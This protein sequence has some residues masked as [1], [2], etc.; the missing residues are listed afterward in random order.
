[1]PPRQFSSLVVVGAFRPKAPFLAI[2]AGQRGRP[3][4]RR[5][6]VPRVMIGSSS[7]PVSPRRRVPSPFRWGPGSPACRPP[8]LLGQTR[9]FRILSS[10]MGSQFGSPRSQGNR[11]MSLAFERLCTAQRNSWFSARVGPPREYGNKW[12]EWTTS[13]LS[14]GQ[15]E[16]QIR[17]AMQAATCL[18][19]VVK[20][21][22][23]P[24]IDG[25]VFAS[26]SS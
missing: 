9:N 25:P 13:G 4:E 16:S 26:L 2:L 18:P 3:N 14:S 11:W 6:V 8:G 20:K 19:A 7:F 5:S 1:M 22:R 15:A 17:S 10:C 23:A 12:S 21:L 24:R